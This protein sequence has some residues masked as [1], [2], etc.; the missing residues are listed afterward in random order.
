MTPWPL[1]PLTWTM[2]SHWGW[3]PMM[4]LWSSGWKS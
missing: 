2:L 3:Y 1:N 4:A